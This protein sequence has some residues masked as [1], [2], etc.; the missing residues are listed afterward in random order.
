MDWTNGLPVSGGASTVGL[1]TGKGVSVGVGAGVSVGAGDGM[2]VSV[3]VA[4]AVLGGTGVSVAT[5]V[6][7]AVAVA[8][9]VGVLAGP[10]SLSSPQPAASIK[11]RAAATRRAERP[12]SAP[13]RVA[14]DPIDPLLSSA[15][16]PP[17]LPLCIP[18]GM[19][20]P[21]AD[22]TASVEPCKAVGFPGLAV[23][24]GR[25]RNEAS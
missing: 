5:A 12:A 19:A 14:A 7:V 13:R 15:A 25:R 1:G 23:A 10:E 22:S 8:V 9:G 2:A 6:A 16:A 18:V 21:C 24:R 20:S 4:V 17:N 11:A 3:N